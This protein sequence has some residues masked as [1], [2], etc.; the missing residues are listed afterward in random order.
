MVGSSS[1]RPGGKQLNSH[2]GIPPGIPPVSVISITLTVQCCTSRPATHARA[3]QQTSR[4][5]VL[6]AVLCGTRE[7]HLLHVSLFVTPIVGCKE[8]KLPRFP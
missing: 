4:T 5:P 6:Q 2:H 3:A 8:L 7:L 1:G